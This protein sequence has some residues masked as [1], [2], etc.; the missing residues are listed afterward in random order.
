M[1]SPVL[2]IL[3]TRGKIF[4]P[5]VVFVWLFWILPSYYIFTQIDSVSV[6]VQRVTELMKTS[7]GKQTL[8]LLAAIVAF[9]LFAIIKSVYMFLRSSQPIGY[10]SHE[11]IQ[12][13]GGK[14]I[15]WD[16]IEDIA[17]QSMGGF[18]VTYRSDLVIYTKNNKT[19]KLPYVSL[20][21]EKLAD[22]IEEARK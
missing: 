18:F 19:H 4:F 6:I 16:D 15:P 9:A 14:M 21:Q 5:M 8:L 3:Q 13:R 10:I 20:T 7:D 2:P 11:W 1:R 17:I 22:M 12:T